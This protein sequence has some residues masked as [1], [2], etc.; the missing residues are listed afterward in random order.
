[1]R[2]AEMAGP[3]FMGLVL[4]A[5]GEQRRNLELKFKVADWREI[6]ERL[7]ALEEAQQDGD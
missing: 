3:E 7:D 6:E 2:Q 5:I 4:R 1:M